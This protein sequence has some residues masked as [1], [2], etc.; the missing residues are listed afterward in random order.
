MFNKLLIAN[1]GEIAC[2]I[3]RTARSL[4]IPTVALFSATDKEALHVKLADEAYYIGPSPAKESYLNADKII[5]IAL[6]AQVEAI[7]PGYGFL[8]ENPEFAERCQKA[9][10]IFVGPSANAIRAMGLKSAAKDLLSKA[11]IPVIP[12]YFGSDQSLST[13]L[14]EAK[15]IGFPLLIKASRGGGG[16]GMRIVHRLEEFS[17]ALTACQREAQASFNDDNVILEKYLHQPRHIEVQIFADSLGHALHLFERDCS[18]Q[19]RHQKI[20]EEA[21]AHGLS[22]DL[23]QRLG[24]TAV[25]V[26]KAIQY[27]NAGTVEFLLDENQQ[28]YFMEMNTRLQVEH[29]VTE[30]ITGLDLVAWQLQIAKGLPLPLQQSQITSQGHAIEVRICA[31]DP[32]NHFFPATG[33]LTRVEWPTVS[34]DIRLDTGVQEGDTVGIYYDSLLAKLVVWGTN[35]MAAIE[36]MEKALD[37]FHILGIPNN[38]AFLRTLFHLSAFKQGNTNTHFIEQHFQPLVAQFQPLGTPSKPQTQ[39]PQCLVAAA[40]F[41]FK[42][43]SQEWTTERYF[44]ASDPH[45]PWDK[46]NNWRLNSVYREPVSLCFEDHILEITDIENT[47]NVYAKKIDNKHLQIQLNDGSLETVFFLSSPNAIYLYWQGQEYLFTL[48]TRNRVSET[49]TPEKTYQLTAPMP[50]TITKIFVQTNDTINISDTILILEA[51]KMEHTIKAPYNGRISALYYVVGD[52]VEMGCELLA[53]EP[54]DEPT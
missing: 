25:Q 27:Q 2:R 21:P 9:G 47:I 26:A 46:G 39:P 36:K 18:I 7:H 29:P 1:R 32:Q 53:L 52:T 43:A 5:N 11:N 10:I 37:H 15:N 50:G 6:K 44:Q 28:F 22:A 35:R 45:S 13:L 3:I 34:A 42:L 12:G 30:M 24:E 16:K 14:K 23:R 19:R 38:I 51:M 54:T 20:V 33:Q 49:S 48:N 41:L 8:S 40:H 4:G 31:E 17:D